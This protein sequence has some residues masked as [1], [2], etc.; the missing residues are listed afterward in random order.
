[1]LF[2]ESLVL[3]SEVVFPLFMLIALGYFMSLFK[4]CDE[5]T[6]NAINKLIFKVFLPVLLFYNVYKTDVADAI[7]PSFMLFCVVAVFAVVAILFAI[8]PMIEKDNRCRGVLIQ[9]IFRSNFVILGLPVTISILGEGNVGATAVMISVV[10]PLFNVLAVVSLEFFRGGRFDKEKLLNI[11]KGIITNPLII[12]SSLGI[13]IFVMNINIPEIIETGIKDISKIATP[14]ALITLGGT[15]KF[16]KLSG[17]ALRIFIVTLSKLV[18]VPALVIFVAVKLGFRGAPIVTLISMF[19]SP[20]AVSSYTM[21]EQMDSDGDLAGQIVVCTT[22][23]SIATIFG[24]VFVL[25]QL[26]LV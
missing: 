16:R 20:T 19:A 5:K 1:M 6:F 8:V 23:F 4:I 21:A 25:K 10:V 15:F 17:N 18:I 13:L 3:A 9:G 26:G 11:L 7:N 12:S 22:L 24:F 2:M 14:L